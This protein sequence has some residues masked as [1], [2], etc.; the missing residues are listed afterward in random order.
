LC[1]GVHDREATMS[2][3]QR[4]AMDASRVIGTPMRQLLSHPLEDRSRVSDPPFW[5]DES[6]DTAHGALPEP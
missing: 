1:A 4:C 3:I 5:I 2:R 6:D